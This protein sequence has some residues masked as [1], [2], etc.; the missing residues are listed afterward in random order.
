MSD[1]DKLKDAIKEYSKAKDD[2]DEK[3]NTANENIRQSQQ[4]Q[5]ELLNH[6]Y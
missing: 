4:E 2:A 3:L 6:P 1:I 5:R